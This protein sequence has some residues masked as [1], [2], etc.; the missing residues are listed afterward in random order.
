MSVRMYLA[1]AVMFGLLGFSS[2]ARSQPIITF[3]FPGAGAT[4]P[5]GIN[6]SGVV[7]GNILTGGVTQGFIRF[8]DGTFSAP[9]VHPDDNQNFTR[10]LGISNSGTVVGDFL[11]FDPSP[12]VSTFHGYK[13]TGGTFTQY[14]HGGPFSTVLTGI[15][16]SG[17]LAGVFGSSVQ[18]NQGFLDTGGG[19]VDFAPAG[20][21]STFVNGLNNLDHAVGQFEDAGGT[22]GF[23]R[24]SSGLIDILN[25]PGALQT[26]ALGIN[27]AGVIVGSFQDA[28]MAFHGF[29][30]ENGNYTPFDVNLPG[31]F[32]TVIRDINNAGQITGFYSNAQ[33]THGFIAAVPEPGAFA[34]LGGLGALLLVGLRRKAIRR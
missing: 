21:T 18:A 19:P 4:R 24:H 8:A 14:D 13:L 11:H 6:D 10:A 32:G 33:G 34:L 15:N 27:D 30:L 17:H 9:L 1:V 22:H 25:V 16:D 5:T 7:V 2:S 31:S 26:F 3:D 28:G 20:A 12:P 23:F 29:F